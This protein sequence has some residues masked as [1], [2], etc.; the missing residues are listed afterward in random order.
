LALPGFPDDYRNKDF[1]GVT[2]LPVGKASGPRFVRYLTR[3]RS[4]RRDLAR[5]ISLEKPDIIHTHDLLTGPPV[6]KA[7]RELVPYIHTSHTSVFTRFSRNWWGRLLMRRLI[8]RPHGVI[9]ASLL[10][11]ERSRALRPELLEN[12]PNG[13]DTQVFRPSQ[14]P[15]GMREA[16]GLSQ[17]NPVVLFAGRFHPVKGL[18]LLFKAMRKVL[19][20]HA[21]AR[22]LVIGGGDSAEE[23]RIEAARS[24]A[25]LGNAV[26]MIGRVAHEDMPAYYASAS[27]LALPSLMEATNIAALEAMACGL[28]VV[29]TAVGGMPEVIEDGVSGRL[30]PP[31]NP[32]SMAEAIISL[33]RND[34]LRRSMGAAAR[35]RIEQRFAWPGIAER[36]VAFYREVIE[37]CLR[38]ER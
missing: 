11:K 3:I 27:I 36:T 14:A 24:A 16:L 37:K 20:A 18:T 22:L 29:A 26:I 23:T 32:A 7:F 10:L 9:A 38:P 2:L 34:D 35:R 15:A 17:E 1:D 21:E 5:F 33:L 31:R 6:A 28:P 12:I 8:G 19:A 4:A 13:V 25:G 30:V